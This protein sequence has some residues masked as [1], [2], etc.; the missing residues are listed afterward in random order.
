MTLLQRLRGEVLLQVPCLEQTLFLYKQGF[1]LSIFTALTT[2][3][4]FNLPWHF[5]PYAG[6]AIQL[7][8]TA[9]GSYVSAN[10]I[11]AR[12]PNGCPSEVAA[13]RWI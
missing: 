10:L 8:I 3:I 9:I 12:V 4:L 7:V 11:G 1:L 6:G 5:I 2:L 13:K